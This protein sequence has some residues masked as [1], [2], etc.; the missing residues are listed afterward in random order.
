VPISLK[1][2]RQVYCSQICRAWCCKNLVFKCDSIDPDIEKFF[3]LRDVVYNKETKDLS[4]PNKCKWL[5]S[6]NKCRL[7]SW[8]PYSCRVY[9]CDKIKSLTVDS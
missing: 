4:V 6:H 9:E 1:A 3:Q 2:K 5:T 7:Y 8:R